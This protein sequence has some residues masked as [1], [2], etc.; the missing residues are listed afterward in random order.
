MD[1]DDHIGFGYVMNQMRNQP[2]E[3][4]AANLYASDT[5]GNKLIKAVYESL[6]LI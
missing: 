3:E 1:L 4:T 2:L 5:R 6:E